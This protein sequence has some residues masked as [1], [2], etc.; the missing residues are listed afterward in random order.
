MREFHLSYPDAMAF[1]INAGFALLAWQC[2]A[3][4]WVKFERTSPGY[5]SQ[6][7]KRDA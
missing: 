6:D 1:P 2:E 3:N 4:P 5:V 7:A